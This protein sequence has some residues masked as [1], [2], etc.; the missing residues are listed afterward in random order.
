MSGRH[1]DCSH[2]ISGRHSSH[3]RIMPARHS[4]CSRIMSGRH[5]DRSHIMPGRHSSRSQEYSGKDDS[6]G[7]T[8]RKVSRR[9]TAFSAAAGR[10]KDL[11]VKTDAPA[12]FCLPLSFTA[13]QSFFPAATDPTTEPPPAEKKRPEDSVPLLRLPLS[14]GKRTETDRRSLEKHP[15]KRPGTAVRR[16]YPAGCCARKRETIASAARREAPPSPSK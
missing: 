16:P 2:I 1:S 11:F 5:T 15:E 7:E 14:Q 10:R 9:K 12:S 3:S 4:D 13:E 6:R 8:L